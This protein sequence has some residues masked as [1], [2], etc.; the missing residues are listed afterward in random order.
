MLEYEGGFLGGLSGVERLRKE[1][2]ADL[3]PCVQSAA[4]VLFIIIVRIEPAGSGAAIA[5]AD[6]GEIHSV[7]GDPAPVDVVLVL[8]NVDARERARGPGVAHAAAAVR[9]EKVRVPAEHGKSVA[10]KQPARGQLSRDIGRYLRRG[11][12]RGFRSGGGLR[13]G[14]RL[15]SGL[16]RRGGLLRRLRGARKRGDKDHNKKQDGAARDQKAELPFG[17]ADAAPA[18]G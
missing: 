1:I 10:A 15:R 9:R 2:N 4:N 17:K 8:G 5:H 3:K 7:G 11:V 13:L 6:H 18:S 14:E 16:R 12:G